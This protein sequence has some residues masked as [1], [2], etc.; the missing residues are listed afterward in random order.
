MHCKKKNKKQKRKKKL[1]YKFP[2]K[3]TLKGKEN[4]LHNRT[5]D[6]R[7]KIVNLTIIRGS[8]SISKQEKHKTKIRYKKEEG[9][10]E[11][12]I[13]GSWNEKEHLAHLFPL[14]RLVFSALLCPFLL[15]FATW[16]PSRLLVRG[17]SIRQFIIYTTA[18]QSPLRHLGFY[19]F[20]L[21]RLLLRFQIPWRRRKVRFAVSLLSR[22]SF[23]PF[24]SLRLASC[25]LGDPFPSNRRLYAESVNLDVL[26]SLIWIA[27]QFHRLMS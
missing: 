20:E 9:K 26:S 3:S 17:Q 25:L 21:E 1:L 16:R 5:V 4:H 7:Q 6:K 10:E 11:T 2:I 8:I 23:F 15:D 12:G 19:G 24:Y 27:C 18:A 14:H 13:C 22:S